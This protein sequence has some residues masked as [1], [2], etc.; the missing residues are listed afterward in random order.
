MVEKNE[1]AKL[2]GVCENPALRAMLVVG[3]RQGLRRKELANLRWA[4]VDL[5]RRI[6]HVVNVTEAGELTES[7]KNR[8][9]PM[10]PDVYEAL[11]GLA[12][13]A[14]SRVEDGRL[15]P[16]LPYAFSWPDGKPYKPDWL[17]HWFAGLV[18]KANV[19]HCTLHDLRRSFSTIAQR[20]GVDRHVVKDLGG[21]SCVSVVEKR[22]SGDI[23]PVYRQA[24]EQIAAAKTV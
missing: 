10:H 4:A 16:A 21:W 1:F 14:P 13:H 8:S 5:E 11:S 6:V 2:L 24:M 23:S 7:R 22:Y 9:L 18:E 20:A 15:V 17:S 19:K 3:Y 12:K